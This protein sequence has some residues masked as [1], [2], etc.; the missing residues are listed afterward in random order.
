MRSL[1]HLGLIA[2]VAVAICGL[3]SGFHAEKMS[4]VA[5]T[6][7]ALA[8]L[9]GS[10]SVFLPEKI[11]RRKLSARPRLSFDELYEQYLR[12]L[13]FRK[14]LLRTLWGESAQELKVD[15]ELL[16]PGDRFAVELA[17]PGFPLVDVNE[18][19]TSRLRQRMRVRQ[20]S[21]KLPEVT[22]LREY[23]E[24]SARLETGTAL[25]GR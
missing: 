18:G 15:A 4:A 23:I 7:L 24:A 19:L 10:L 9:Y 13:P 25:A 5:W 16:R 3:L 8:V 11:R 14:E 12:D 17:V 22:T 6:V 1:T 2:L 21:L 20:Q